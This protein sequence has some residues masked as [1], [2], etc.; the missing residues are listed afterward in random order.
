LAETA[1]QK[2]FVSFLFDF[3]GVGRSTGAFD[4]GFGEQQD[5][6]CALNYLASR[7][8]VRSDQIFVV[9]HSLG[10][11]VSLYALQD[12]RRVKGLVLW[13][14]PKNHDYNVRKF[15]KRTRGRIGL[16]TFLLFSRIDRFV[17]VSKIFKL[18]VFGIKLRLR[19]VR[20]KLMKLNEYEVIPNLK[21]PVLIVV[22][23]ADNIHSVDEVRDVFSV[24]HDPKT[25]VIIES[26]DHSDSG[27]ED[28]LI[29][30]T[31]EWMEKQVASRSFGS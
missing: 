21:M 2:G 6:K 16:R 28:E 27:K 10:A 26:A 25:L 12:E 7:R 29:A 31:V 3:R 11:A 5:A 9:G 13:S 19:Y 1:C 24:A 30:K 14:P 18:E 4:Y 17:N 8:E 22:G 20:E 23:D 15:I